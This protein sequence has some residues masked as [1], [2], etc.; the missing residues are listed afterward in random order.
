MKVRGASFLFAAL[1]AATPAWSQAISPAQ[2]HPLSTGVVGGISAGL[3]NAGAAVG[4]TFTFDVTDRISVEARGVHME[5]GSGQSGVE[6]TAALLVTLV[7][8]KTAA[9]Y[10]SFGGG[11]Y[12]ASFDLGNRELFGMMGEDFAPGTMFVA[13]A[14]MPG[15]AVMGPNMGSRMPLYDGAWHG[16]W[17]GDTFTSSHMPDFYA[18]RLGEMMVPENGHWTSRT[19]T[20]P[21]LTVGGGL[22]L[23]LTRR[24]YLRPDVRG[25]VVFSGDRTVLTTMNVGLGVRF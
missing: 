25:L 24:V 14:A 6:A 20:D 2:P 4:G 15:Y 7:R 16:P 18:S 11:V 23:N 1:L 9:P 17:T 10:V 21:A 13:L 19:F 22:T 3:G 8:T 12:R 5:R